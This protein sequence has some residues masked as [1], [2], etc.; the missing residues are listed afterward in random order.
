MKHAKKGKISDTVSFRV[1]TDLFPVLE[2]RARSANVSVHIMARQ[3]VLDAL[4]GEAEADRLKAIASAVSE[5]KDET[6]Q[7]RQ[8]FRRIAEVLLVIVGKKDPQDVRAWLEAKI[9]S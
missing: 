4:A 1:G 3:L 7:G 9:S 5:L 6:A 8:D 2:Q